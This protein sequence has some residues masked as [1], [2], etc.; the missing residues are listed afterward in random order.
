MTEQY[1]SLCAS[2][3]GERYDGDAENAAK[4]LQQYLASGTVLDVGGGEGRNA[5]LLAEQGFQ[6][7][8]TDL[9]HVGLQKLAAKANEQQLE[10][11]TKV[12]D[13]VTDGVHESYDAFV[14]S[15]VLHH[16]P[17][18]NVE[19]VLRVCQEQTRPGGCH[20]IATFAAHGGLYE[21]NQHSGRFYATKA[22]LRD[23][24]DGWVIRECIQGETLAQARDKNGERMK[25]DTIQFI[26]QKPA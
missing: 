4:R 7:T 6:V 8:V 26:A 15:F 17:A 13:I 21:R 16:I 14:F 12:S 11:A 2:K 20:V 9:S 3:A 5:L 10:I 24:Y 25:N 23:V 22:H 19:H 1:D 18:V